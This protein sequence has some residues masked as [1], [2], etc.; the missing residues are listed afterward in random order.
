MK[1]KNTSTILIIIV[2]IIF[3]ISFLMSITY[4]EKIIRLE[5]CFE[6]EGV[7]VKIQSE[8]Y[9]TT[10][11]PNMTVPYEP[12]ITYRGID[13]YVRARF[14]VSNENLTPDK[15]NGLSDKWVRRGEYYYYT[16]PVKHN[17]VLSTF[18]SFH[19]PEKWDESSGDLRMGSDLTITALCDAVQADNFSP[20]FEKENP[21]GD[22][23]IEDNMYDGNM[24]SE[25]TG[26][27]G[28]PV[29]LKTKGSSRYA[30]DSEML[31]NRKFKPGDT[32]ENDIV[33]CNESSNSTELLFF[34]E[35]VM[36]RSAYNLLDVFTLKMYIDEKQF[37]N[38]P[39]RAESLN[40]WKSLIKMEPG[41]TH[42]VHYEIG[43]P[44]E[45][46]NC[47]QL[48]EQNFVWNMTMHEVSDMPLTG[49]NT[50]L[51]LWIILMIISGVILKKIR[52][53]NKKD[54]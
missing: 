14:I 26:D 44:A 4:A 38:G 31:C 43:A 10:L 53:K 33:I 52:K 25:Y 19:I 50:K 16:E 37:Y 51:F 13:A 24:Y 46:H 54:E 7:D 36:A 47:Y 6:T 5:G 48:Q 30:L 42:K 22:L 2:N 40:S 3:L 32:Y 41:T 28:T 21:W 8:E 45:M 34:V 1:Q 29:F 18:K 11:S 9:N 17:T 39:L 27:A 35:N 49:D 15:F 12:V 23:F 20:D